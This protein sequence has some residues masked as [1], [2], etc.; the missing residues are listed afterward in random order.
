NYV[1]TID[2]NLAF[3]DEQ[4]KANVDI[5]QTCNAFYSG[6]TV[7]FFAEGMGCA[8]TATVADV[9]YHEYEH[10]VHEHEIVPGV[11]QFDGSFS[12]GQSDF[13]AA[14]ITGDSGMG[15]GF[16]LNDEPLRELDPVGDEARWPDNVGEI[17]KQ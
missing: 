15:R 4:T 11:G 6:G 7:N 5:G 12:E 10:G 8:N 9:I 17:H 3:L 16:K 2:P 1:R 13:I 14:S